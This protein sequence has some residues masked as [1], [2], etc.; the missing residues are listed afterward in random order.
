MNNYF[1]SKYSSKIINQHTLG[2]YQ[3]A[4]FTGSNSKNFFFWKI[5]TKFIYANILLEVDEINLF[6]LH[7]L[8]ANIDQCI[9]IKLDL[10][11]RI[12]NCGPN[13]D[14]NQFLDFVSFIFMIFFFCI[15]PN[16]TSDRSQFFFLSLLY[17]SRL[18]LLF[19]IILV[20]F[21]KI[22]ITS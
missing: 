12:V 19:V 5:I 15:L 17:T 20:F 13:K 9:E 7:P 4:T 22:G 21:F 16:S 2:F 6:L 1:L 3:N 14:D 8:N 10:T 18:R 11:S